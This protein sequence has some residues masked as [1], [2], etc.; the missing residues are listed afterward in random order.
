MTTLAVSVTGVEQMALSV[1]QPWAYLLVTG[2]KDVE[3]RRWRT[4]YR[5]WLWIH[6]SQSLD[7]QAYAALVG[8]GVDLPPAAQLPRGALLGAVELLGCVRDSSSRWA[9]PGMWHWQI[10]G[11]W[12]LPEPI[13]MRGRQRLFRVELPWRWAA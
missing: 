9:E 1:W 3:N 2:T 8:E 4:A 5:G 13:S 6:A 11:S 10:E 7:E 12:A